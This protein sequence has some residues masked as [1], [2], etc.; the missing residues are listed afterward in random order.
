M[1]W[2]QAFYWMASL[3][4]LFMFGTIAF[5]EAVGGPVPGIEQEL[6]WAQ[7]RNLATGQRIRSVIFLGEKVT[8]GTLAAGTLGGPY[9]TY[10]DLEAAAGAGSPVAL[11]ARRFFDF[12]NSKVG[13]AKAKVRVAVI[14]EKSDGTA[15]VQT[16]TF[17]T[18]ATGAG[19]W[20][21]LIG[22]FQVRVN[23]TVGMTAIQ[24]AAALK[25]AFDDLGWEA[26]PPLACTIPAN[27]NDHKATFTATVKGAH[28]NS[29]GLS[30][31]QDASCG[32]TATWSGSY[33]GAA[34]G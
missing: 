4:I 18:T 32:T 29:I 22:G 19:T 13:K 11:L 27:P 28:L 25:A 6:H 3:S 17:A 24:Q 16:C 2:L 20:I 10:S 9:A 30:T 5:T 7:G 31:L 12:N 23:V 34:G 15:A 14:V 26:K 21:F 1:D 8:A 33:M